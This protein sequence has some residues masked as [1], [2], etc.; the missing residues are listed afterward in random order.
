LQAIECVGARAHVL[1]AVNKHLIG[2]AGIIIAVSKNCYYIALD[3]PSA[4]ADMPASAA[5]PA[6][7]GTSKKEEAVSQQKRK[8]AWP[9]DKALLVVKEECI[10]GLVLPSKG[11][12]ASAGAGA[13]G[14]V[15]AH[16][17]E[18]ELFKDEAVP[19]G[20]HI[21]ATSACA[22]SVQQDAAAV[23]AAGRFDRNERLQDGREGRMCVLYGK[24][25][26]PHCF[27]TKT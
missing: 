21:D 9:T 5:G 12:W 1:D 18:Q 14:E 24:H 22:V 15:P 16:K 25:Y 23:A 13:A 7:A 6:S 2:A 17:T 10:L 19:S 26:L 11:S 20:G 3:A 8:H 27:L 4:P